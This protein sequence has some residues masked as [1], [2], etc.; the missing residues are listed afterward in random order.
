M[1]FHIT[2]TLILIAVAVVA[3]AFEER[4]P[5]E[6]TAIGVVAVL[7][8][9][10][11]IYPLT[12][13]AGVRLI[14]PEGLLAGFANP[15]LVTVMSLLVVGQ[16]LVRSGALENVAGFAASIGGSPRVTIAILLLATALVSA[17]MNNTPV[18]VLMLPVLA[19]VAS[20]ARISASRVMMPLS[21]ITILGGMTTLVGSSTNLIV[22]GTATTLGQP[23]LG[24]FSM[25]PIAIVLA[26]V[27]ALY[28]LFI[29]PRLLPDRATMAQ[30]LRGP[31]Q[32]HQFIA[33][34]TIGPGHQFE[35]ATATAG[36]FPTLK[37][38]TVLMIQRGDHA[39]L[40]PFDEETIR[41]RDVVM[42][43]ATRAVLTEA[44][45]G[46]AGLISSLLESGDGEASRESTLVLAEA[47]VSPGSRMVG[48]P[49]EQ[50]GLYGVTGC[51]VLG[52]QRHS[53]MIRSRINSIRLEAGDVL[54]IGGSHAEMRALR[55]DRDIVL[56][57]W[58]RSEIEAAPKGKQALAIFFAVVV[59]AAT[60]LLP[61]VVSAVAGAA[62]M[63]LLDVL[64]VRQ[65]ARAFDRRLFLLVGSS[66]AMAVPM[67]ATGA[68][69]AIAHTLVGWMDGASA[70]MQLSGFFLLVALMTNVL[71]N[72][73]AAALFTPIAL[74][75]ATQTG[76]SPTIWLITVILATNCSFA[77]PIGYQTNLLVMAPGH[78]TFGDFM[79]AGA[80]LVFILWIVFTVTVTW[81]Y[82]V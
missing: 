38:M 59:T 3:Y 75:L 24:F 18:V 76:V 21:F 12:D 41:A 6:A 46:D 66:L 51:V 13:A 35:G 78:Y 56:M 37:N 71:S 31:S 65:M 8:L 72:N 7:L 79:R 39:I 1:D 2:F 19:A 77:T 27:G 30:A 54:L 23:L 43:A 60:G 15:A 17:V 68:A 28:V 50:S 69:A 52:V 9:V 82:G 58:S 22:A 53:R 16:G 42:V 48:Q 40:P 74:Q 14:T 29:V 32:S 34:L 62:A 67:E 49:I 10:F 80:P 55:A 70:T 61:I 63:V 73:A 36:M 44:I 4:I 57:E 47:M 33:E 20:K 11:Q 5:L 25:T 45:R 26:A 64:N 81:Y